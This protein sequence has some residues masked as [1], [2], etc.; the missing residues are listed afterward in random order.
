MSEFDDPTQTFDEAG[1]SQLSRHTATILK[2]RRAELGLSVSEV[3][4]R[5]DQR[6]GSVHF[7][8]LENGGETI[9]IDL[10]LELCGV[11]QLRIDQVIEQA[12]RATALE[13]A[14]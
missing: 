6:I 2:N 5:L 9:L 4:A 1:I 14:G 7:G 13:A 10:F 11:Y 3:R 8:Q 12:V